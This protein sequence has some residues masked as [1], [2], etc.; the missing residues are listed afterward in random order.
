MTLTTGR[1][2]SEE[3]EA[4]PSP[5]ESE[6]RVARTDRL[7]KR[8]TFLAFHLPFSILV[9]IVPVALLAWAGWRLNDRHTTAQAR[10]DQLATVRSFAAAQQ[11][12]NEERI[13]HVEHLVGRL[14]HKRI[15]TA[16]GALQVAADEA[17][18]ILGALAVFVLDPSGRAIALS[19]AT[20]PD[21]TSTIGHSYADRPYFREAIERN[22]TAVSPL[23]VGRQLGRPNVVFATPLHDGDRVVGVLAMAF[24]LATFTRAMIPHAP[25]TFGHLFLADADGHL[26]RIGSDGQPSIDGIATVPFGQL[27][28]TEAGSRLISTGGRGRLVTWEP[29]PALRMAVGMEVDFDEIMDEERREFAAE[30]AVVVTVA[31]LLAVGGSIVTGVVGAREIDRVR[32]YMQRLTSPRTTATGL[33][34]F[35]IREFQR[36]AEDARAMATAIEQRGREIEILYD[37]DRALAGVAGVDELP[38][39]AAERVVAVLGF[40]SA[41]VFLLDQEAPV[42]RLHHA[43]RMPAAV[44]E[45]LRTIPL[46]TGVAGRAI[47]E[48]RAVIMSIEEYEA[49]GAVS[50]IEP[51]R[52]AGFVTFVSAPLVAH[53]EVFG[54]ISFASARR[55]LASPWLTSLLTSVG[56]QIGIAIAH[57]RDREREVSQERMAVLGRL[58]AGVAHELRNPLTVMSARLELLERRGAGQDGL[59][60]LSAHDLARIEEA[61][62]RMRQ[63]VAGLSSYSRPAKAELVD[64]DVSELLRAV[65]ELVG[66]EAKKKGV[67]IEVATAPSLPRVLADRGEMTQILVNLA[68]NAIE[69]MAE[70]GVLTLRAGTAP[71]AAA[72]TGQDVRVVVEVID[73]GPGIELDVLPRI[74][75]PFFTTKREGTGLGLSIVRSLIDKQPGADVSVHTLRGQGTSF[76]ITLPAHRAQ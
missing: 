45:Q 26:L 6:G 75:D 9:T 39:I 73:T 31:V 1:T 29:V 21:G 32:R 19:P 16:P 23:F 76:T 52:S 66:Y 36:I 11:I 13:R 58:A 3:P 67:R 61:V 37:L 54:A 22:A 5:E 17:R 57:A 64:L 2:T 72:D 10:I 24:E 4:R 33:P 48:R 8:P 68:S 56:T 60:S 25:A 40:D 69:A 53:G 50:A 41:A 74:W 49:I 30:V 55:L 43:Y 20:A 62:D 65:G 70:G 18:A 47:D 35:R 38:R 27:P 14:E 28:I 42:L 12:G 34:R 71:P 46:G 59:V 7:K 51:V 63:I 15:Q 44:E